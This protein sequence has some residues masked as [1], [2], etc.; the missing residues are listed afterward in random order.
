MGARLAAQVVRRGVRRRDG[1]LDGACGTSL[2]M[3]S[4]LWGARR[5]LDEAGFVG[6]DDGLDAVAYAELHEDPAGV[7]LDGL[8]RYAQQKGDFGVGAS[9]RDVTQGVQLALRGRLEL[10]GSLCSRRRAA[11]ERLDEAPRD[12]RREEGVAG[13]RAAHGI[14]QLLRARALEQEAA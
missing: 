12:L 6:E 1:A 14:E 11:H 2:R 7:C 4:A 3:R 5:G 8:V 10:D 13:D 9:G